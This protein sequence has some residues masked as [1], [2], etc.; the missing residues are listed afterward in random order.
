MH[1]PGPTALAIGLAFACQPE[2]VDTERCADVTAQI[3]L[4]LEDYTDAGLLLPGARPCELGPEDFDPRTT[5]ESREYLLG[6]FANACVQQA[7]ACWAIPS[8]AP[9]PPAFVG[10]SA[11]D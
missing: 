9:P 3:E 1:S 8:A 11:P 2:A 4:A 10:G 5:A 7:D 6:A